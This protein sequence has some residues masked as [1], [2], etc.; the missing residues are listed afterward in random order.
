MRNGQKAVENMY[1]KIKTE[2]SP[3]DKYMK[4]I[5]MKV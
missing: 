1:L 3:R 5:V 2:S 4:V